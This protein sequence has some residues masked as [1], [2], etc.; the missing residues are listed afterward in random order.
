MM[1][2][3]QRT[4]PVHRKYLSLDPLLNER[5]RR[6]WAAAEAREIDWGGVTTIAAGLWELQAA[7]A[8]DQVGGPPHCVRRP[9]GGRRPLVEHDTRLLKDLGA[10]VDP[11]TR[12]DPQSSLRWTYKSTHKLAEALRQQGHAV[13]Y[14]TVAIPLKAR[15]K[16]TKR[17]GR[18]GQVPDMPVSEAA[19]HDLR[20]DLTELLDQ[21]L[22]R[23]PEK[24]RIPIVLCELEGRTHKEAA[25]QL[26][27]PIGTV[28]S[29]LSRAKSTLARRLSRQGASLSVNSLAVLLAHF[30]AEGA[31]MAGV[32]SAE[33][34][35][36]TGRC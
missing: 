25:I 33:V 14:R 11:V 8:G 6:L 32:V 2:D 19:S 15:A 17:R 4:E 31:L 16:R 7:V 12:G 13:G 22:S 26:G 18:E 23:L 36:L 34:T 10:L 9:G 21:E 27:W 5:L 20:D 1:V 3:P 24:Y 30:A 29:R 35:A 28:S